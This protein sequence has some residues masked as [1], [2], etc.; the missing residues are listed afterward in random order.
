MRSR[1]QEHCS[2]NGALWQTVDVS[3]LRTARDR[4]RSEVTHEILATARDHLAEHGAAGLSLRAVAR[5]LG[6]VSSAVYRYVA[7]RDALLTMLIV[8]AYDSLGDAV[9][10]AAGTGGPGRERW[11]AAALAIRAWAID[12]RQEY[13]LLYGSPVPGYEAPPDTVGPGVR[14]PLALVGIVRDAHSSGSLAATTPPA[15]LSP[16]VQTELAA[17]A[18][19]VAPDLPAE[20]LFLGI[21]GW[22]QLFGLLS[23]ELS[24]QTRGMVEDHGALYADMAALTADRIGLR[25]G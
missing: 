6:L 24:G 8:E 13:L 5:D 21:L 22:T 2:G 20:V 11:I 14:T 25:A 19:Q 9:E 15:D 4:A 23:F 17:L 18:R 1:C 12:H 10:A 3:T 7:S 16:V